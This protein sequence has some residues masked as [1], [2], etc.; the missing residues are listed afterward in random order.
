MGNNAELAITNEMKQLHW[1]N[2]YQ[3]KHWH[4]LSKKQK[5]QILDSHIFVEQ[6]RDCKIKARKVIG[7]DRQRDYITKEEVELSDRFGGGSD[8]YLYDQIPRM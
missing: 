2:L 3:P 6:K 1:R 7:G 5:E 8:A 4:D